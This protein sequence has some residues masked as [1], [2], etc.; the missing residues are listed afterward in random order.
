M[1]KLNKNKGTFLHKIYGSHVVSVYEKTSISGWN[2]QMLAIGCGDKR[3][4]VLSIK[5]QPASGIRVT[6]T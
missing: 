1:H 2:S 4:Q 3:Y 6:S 5:T